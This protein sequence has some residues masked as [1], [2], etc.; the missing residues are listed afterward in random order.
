M[1]DRAAGFEPCDYWRSLG[2]NFFFKNLVVENRL[3][4]QGFHTSAGGILLYNW[5]RNVA[6]ADIRAM[7]SQALIFLDLEGLQVEAS[8]GPF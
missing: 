1:T 4:D 2:G 8:L 7:D 3:S 5:R 6:N